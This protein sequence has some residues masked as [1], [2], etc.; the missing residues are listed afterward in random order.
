MDVKMFRSI[1]QHAANT[2]Q[3]C[4]SPVYALSFVA[5]MA[6]AGLPP[7]TFIFHNSAFFQKKLVRALWQE[8][9]Y[10]TGCLFKVAG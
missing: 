10:K 8:R 2:K 7:P 5:F 1:F 4:L 6:S 3:K 9:S